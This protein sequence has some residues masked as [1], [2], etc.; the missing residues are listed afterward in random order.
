MAVMEH[1]IT[2]Q[3]FLCAV[4][5]ATTNYEYLVKYHILTTAFKAMI[6]QEGCYINTLQRCSALINYV[7][8]YLIIE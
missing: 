6:L 4:A 8:I 3:S 2:N 5:I 7:V 1:Y